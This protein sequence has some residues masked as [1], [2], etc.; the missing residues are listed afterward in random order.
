MNLG[1]VKTFLIILFLGINIYLVLSMH[2]SARFTVDKSTKE[3]CVALLE[4]RGVTLDVAKIPEYTVNLNNIDTHNIVHSKAFLKNSLAKVSGNTF[5]VPAKPEELSEP[6]P[7]TIKQF[8]KGL[9]FNTKYMNVNYSDSKKAWYATCTVGGYRIF[10]NVVKISAKPDEGHF[11]LEGTWYDPATNKVLARTRQRNTV[12]ITSVLLD[13]TQN[14]SI[15]KNAPFEITDIS[16]GYLAGKAYGKASHV[17]SAAL[18]YYRIK[19]N[20][21][22]VYYFDAQSGT[23]LEN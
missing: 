11:V 7:T 4:K 17:T 15:M 6:N 21:G 10:D 5:S 14:E 16:Y 1:K 9:G 3:S 12:Y 22:N 8:L 19:D 13:M 2:Y 23:Y 18:P 20:L